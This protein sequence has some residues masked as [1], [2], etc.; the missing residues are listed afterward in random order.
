MG[1][2]G[3]V[4]GALWSLAVAIWWLAPVEISLVLAAMACAYVAVLL[5]P[6]DRRW[7]PVTIYRRPPVPW[8]PGQDPAELVRYVDLPA[9]VAD[10]SAAPTLAPALERLAPVIPLRPAA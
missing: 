6:R 9:E 10:V 2:V 5:V 4:L 8:A 1:L 7:M 3:D